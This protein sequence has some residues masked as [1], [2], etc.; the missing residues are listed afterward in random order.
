MKLALVE[1][2]RHAGEKEGPERG[3]PAL[4]SERLGNF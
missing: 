4:L 1:C 2:S 3:I